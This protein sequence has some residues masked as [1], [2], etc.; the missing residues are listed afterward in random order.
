[1]QVDGGVFHFQSPHDIDLL[2]DETGMWAFGADSVERLL[3]SYADIPAGSVANIE[4]SSLRRFVYRNLTSEGLEPTDEAWAEG[5]HFD[6]SVRVTFREQ[7]GAEGH[8]DIPYRE[9]RSD[10]TSNT[11]EARGTTSYTVRGAGTLA[12]SVRLVPGSTVDRP[13]QETLFGGI[14]VGAQGVIGRR[15]DSQVRNCLDGWVCVWDTTAAL[16]KDGTVLLRTGD[17]GLR[18]DVRDGVLI[19]RGDGRGWVPL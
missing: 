17:Y 18:M 15:Y 2:S 19:N 14:D 5:M 1:M 11:Y 13:L 4:V 6:T 3:G 12:I 10:G 16:V 7:T 9:I 8:A